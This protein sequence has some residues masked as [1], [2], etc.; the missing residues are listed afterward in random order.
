MH[1]LFRPQNYPSDTLPWRRQP[2]LIYSIQ[3]HQL[4]IKHSS[5]HIW[6]CEVQSVSQHYKSLLYHAVVSFGS[7]IKSSLCFSHA[8]DVWLHWSTMDLPEETLLRKTDFPFP[9][10]YQ[11]PMARGEILC[12]LLSPYWHFLW[13]EFAQILCTLS[14]PLWVH[15]CSCAAVSRK[16][17]IY[18]Y[19]HVCV[20]VCASVRA[21][22]CRC[23]WRPKEDIWS[24][25]NGIQANVS[26]PKWVLGKEQQEFLPCW[27]VFLA[28]YLHSWWCPI[29]LGYDAI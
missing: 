24:P 20:C 11:L 29:W 14:Q 28:L 7:P 25:G 3:F 18:L 22:K 10:N 8:P 6:M 1:G 16:N 23:S 9:S 27:D 19:L 2:I 15:M 4:W 13:L 12:F 5:S 17:K 21:S 26:H